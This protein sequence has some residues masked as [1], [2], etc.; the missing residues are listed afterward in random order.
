MSND[1]PI[2]PSQ[3]E[4]EGWMV[5][6]GSSAHDSNES[7]LSEEESVAPRKRK[8]TKGSLSPRA[9]KSPRLSINDISVKSTGPLSFGSQ[10]GYS[11]GTASASASTITHTGASGS[12][13][14]NASVSKGDASISLGSSGVTRL[15]NRLPGVSSAPRPIQRSSIP[16]GN[17]SHFKIDRPKVPRSSQV[18]STAQSSASA[19]TLKAKEQDH[20]NRSTSS[21]SLPEPSVLLRSFS[22]PTTHS[23]RKDPNVTGNTKDTARRKLNRASNM[24]SITGRQKAFNARTSNPDLVT[25]VNKPHLVDDAGVIVISSDSEVEA[26][27]TVKKS[28]SRHLQSSTRNNPAD[29]GQDNEQTTKAFLSDSDGAIDLTNDQDIPSIH[30][31]EQTREAKGKDDIGRL[32]KTDVPD[33]SLRSSIVSRAHV[34]VQE[35]LKG[36]NAASHATQ[37]DRYIPSDLESRRTTASPVVRLPLPANNGDCSNRQL[38]SKIS[39]P[40]AGSSNAATKTMGQTQPSLADVISTSLGGTSSTP[41]V[42]RPLR[43]LHDVPRPTQLLRS[44]SSK[45]VPPRKLAPP[46][47]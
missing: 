32:P 30:P 33:T 7:N 6:D 23:K 26:Q 29:L 25:S 20:D 19:S 24:A 40:V 12:G 42:H 9:A 10:H 27:I 22:S 4:V 3:T 13:Q 43:P 14:G 39:T 11:L 34:P 8:V 41:K 16:D 46:A 5:L 44:S 37:P 36:S 45:V 35:Q 28:Y 31:T 38:S 15:K 17:G 18:A 47:S 2:P 21:D 1:R